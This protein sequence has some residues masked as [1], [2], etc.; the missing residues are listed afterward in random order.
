MS[1]EVNYWL[2]GYVECLWNMKCAVRDLGVMGLNPTHVELG[3]NN[4]I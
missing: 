3:V 2:S 4:Y 1:N